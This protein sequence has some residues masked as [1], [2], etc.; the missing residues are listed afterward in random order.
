MV[1]RTELQVEGDQEAVSI[2]L[3]APTGW[4]KAEE[5]ATNARD[6][7]EK[8]FEKAQRRADEERTNTEAKV[9][10]KEKAG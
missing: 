3:P 8:E 6:E 4:K 10:A 7:E 2:E 1:R 9:E 5:A